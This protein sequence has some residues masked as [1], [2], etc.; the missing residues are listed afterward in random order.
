MGWEYD[1]GGTLVVGKDVRLEHHCIL[2]VA[3]SPHSPYICY[4][5]KIDHCIIFCGMLLS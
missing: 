4:D 5:C 2:H 1:F 3:C